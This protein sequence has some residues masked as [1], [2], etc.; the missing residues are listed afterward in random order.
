MKKT[1]LSGRY[2]TALHQFSL[3]QGREED[4]Y[5]D[6]LLL[7]NVFAENRELRVVVESPV[8]PAEKKIAIFDAIFEGK[9]NSIT[10]GFFKLIIT[11]RREPALVDMFDNFVEC[12]NAN[13]HIKIATLTTA[14]QLE[15][16][17]L[18]Q[19]KALLEEQTRSTIIIK[20][21]VNPKIIGGVIVHVDDFLFDASI[22]GKINKLRVEFS[23]N[24]YQTKY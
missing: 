1:K 19:I 16:A 9:I 23:H 15:D 6:I 24:L 7:Q 2:A 11:K 5:Q 12:Y 3:E 18:A 4:V 14:T 8:M 17:L 22:I 21:V 10:A 13:H 20:Q